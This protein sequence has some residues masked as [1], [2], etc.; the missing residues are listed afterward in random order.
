MP[1]K[2]NNSIF[3]NDNIDN[4]HKTMT[5][6]KWIVVFTGFLFTLCIAFV[7]YMYIA[8]KIDTAYDTTA[9][10]SCI[11]VSGSI[12]GSN[13]CWYSKKAASEN[14]YKLRMGLYSDATRIRLEYN[15]QMMILK[16]KYN[17]TEDDIR[18]INESGDIDEMMDGAMNDVVSDLDTYRD[19][20]ECPNQIEQV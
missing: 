11:T 5:W 19:D 13:L 14:H 16:Q 7:M 3:N 10:V 20:A 2:S 1:Y 17:M 6:S 8:G 15:E 18:E 9:I 12:F 4:N